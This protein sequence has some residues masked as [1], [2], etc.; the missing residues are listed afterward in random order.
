MTGHDIVCSVTVAST[1][2][3]ICMLIHNLWRVWRGL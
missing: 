3:G 1:C 2:A